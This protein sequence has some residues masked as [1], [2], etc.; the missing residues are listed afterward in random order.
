MIDPFLPENSD[1]YNV[2]YLGLD[3][4]EVPGQVCHHFHV[5]AVNEDETLINGDYYFESNSF[6]MIKVDFSPAK[7]VK[8]TMFKMKNLN[9]SILLSPTPEGYW[10]PSRFDIEGKGK[11]MFFIGV[12]FS[13][14]EYYRNPVI[15]GG[16]DDSVFEVDN[17][18]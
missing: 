7:L 2:K 14:T 18:K 9:M 10:L 13:G 5:K 15:N 6:N 16:I 4:E 8:K 12:N 11:A 1:I 17:G 3:N